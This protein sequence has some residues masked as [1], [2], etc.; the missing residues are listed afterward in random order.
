MTEQPKSRGCVKSVSSK[1]GNDQF[2]DMKSFVEMSRRIH[3]FKNEFSHSLS[4]EPTWL[5]ASVFSLS[6]LLRHVTVPTWLSFFLG[7]K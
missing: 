3:W 2:F 5:G 6:V 4:P 7:I 1:F